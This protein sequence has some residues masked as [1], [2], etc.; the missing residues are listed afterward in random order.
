LVRSVWHDIDLT[1]KASPNVLTGFGASGVR[2]L[3]VA[4]TQDWLRD[5]DARVASVALDGSSVALAVAV[6]GET[7]VDIA[8]GSG[9][10]P[11]ILE[12]PSAPPGR[13]AFGAVLSGSENTIFV[14]GG[15]LPSLDFASDLWSFDLA[16]QRWQKLPMSGVV[17]QKVL[18]A[19]F[20]PE[21]R[22]IYLVD[23]VKFGFLHW[24]RLL[25]IDIASLA[26][27]TLGTALR[28]PN[29]DRIYLSN[30]PKGEMILV[31]SSTQQENYI[32]VRYAYNANGNLVLKKGFHGEGVVALEPTITA[33]GVTLPLEDGNT[34]K[35]LFRTTEDIKPGVLHLLG[36]CL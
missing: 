36:E 6:Q 4:E 9:S 23:E 16:R 1:P 15:V 7:L 22:S 11:G 32:A 35:N 29:R 13:T 21:N 33:R 18:A 31:S 14:V 20:R 17:P 24:R 10:G 26:S 25:R 2:W 28:N 5:T 12:A 30:A 3:P 19:T 8:H 34:V 27:E